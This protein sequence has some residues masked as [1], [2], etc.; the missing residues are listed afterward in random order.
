MYKNVCVYLPKYIHIC[1]YKRIYTGMYIV[2]E[3]FLQVSFNSILC[4]VLLM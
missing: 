4:Y 1:I 2:N 3:I